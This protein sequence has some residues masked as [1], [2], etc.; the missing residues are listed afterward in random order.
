MVESPQLHK[1]RLH[2]RI[3]DVK[4]GLREEAYAFVK[5]LKQKML[6]PEWKVH[7]TKL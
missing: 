7:E 4:E 3:H 2:W 1:G 6:W 5:E